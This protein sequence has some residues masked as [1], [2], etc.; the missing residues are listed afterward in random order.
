MRL[1]LALAALSL[2]SF[3]APPLSTPDEGVLQSADRK[4]DGGK[5]KDKEEDEED[6]RVAAQ[7]PALPVCPIG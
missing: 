2:T 3:E 6:C 4:R 1:L 5:K 7:V